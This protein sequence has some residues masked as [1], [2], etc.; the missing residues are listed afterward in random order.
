[1]SFFESYLSFPPESTVV[2]ADTASTVKLQVAVPSAATEV[3]VPL[4]S[5]VSH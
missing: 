2:S 4:R 5:I 3:Q 1:L